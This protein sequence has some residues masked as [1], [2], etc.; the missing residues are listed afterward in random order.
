MTS[1]CFSTILLHWTSQCLSTILPSNVSPL[2]NTSRQD[3]SSTVLTSY[4]TTR[5]LTL[6]HNTSTCE[7]AKEAGFLVRSA[8]AKSPPN[9]SIRSVVTEF[10]HQQPRNTGLSIQQTS[11]CGPGSPSLSFNPQ[12]WSLICSSETSFGSGIAEAPAPMALE[13]EMCSMVTP[14]DP[15]AKGCWLPWSNTADPPNI[16]WHSET[17]WFIG[18]VARWCQMPEAIS[19]SNKKYR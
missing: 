5:P 2:P 17:S 3:F 4:N 11:S 18:K 13:L 15:W 9:S 12:M 6:L 19:L 10:V 8:S 7:N 1:H 14:S 16:H